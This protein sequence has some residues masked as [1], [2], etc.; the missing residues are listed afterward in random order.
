MITLRTSH[1]IELLREAGRIVAKTHEYLAQFIKP[2]ITTKELDKLAEEFIISCNATPSF[3]GLYGFKGSICISLNDMVIHGI[4]DKTILKDGD[5]IKL[6]IGACYKGYHGDSAW[7]YAVGNV[8][9]QA[10]FLMKVTHDAL[11]EGLKQAKPGNRVGDISAAIQEHVASNGCTSPYDYTGHG[12]GTSV[13]EDPNVP[14]Y[15]RKGHGPKLKVGM[16]L[17]VEPMVHLGKADV[18][19]ISDGW[20]VKTVDHSL[21]AHYEHTIVITEDGYQILTTL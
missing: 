18:Y 10:R 4:P 9:E 21:T 7:T 6:D 17:A 15:G 3:K 13:H 2:G 5:V 1:E 12:V 8:S 14:N 16:V 19:V 11:F 20:G